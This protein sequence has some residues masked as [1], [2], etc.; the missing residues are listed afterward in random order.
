MGTAGN[1][2]ARNTSFLNGGRGIDAIAGTIDGGG[3]RAFQNALSPQCSGVL[4]R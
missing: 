2:L 3:N 4:C 1:R